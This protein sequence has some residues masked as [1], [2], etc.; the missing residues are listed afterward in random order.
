[1]R[2]A[3]SSSCRA[4]PQCYS[5]AHPPPSAVCPHAAHQPR[6]PERS[7]RI[8]GP[9]LL[10]T[11]VR[12]AFHDCASAT[13]DGCIDTADALN[14]PGLGEMQQ[15]LQPLCAN[16]SLATADCWAAAASIALEEASYNGADLARVPLF[17]GRADTATCTG[18]TQRNPEALFP[19]ASA[20]AALEPHTH[21]SSSTTACTPSFWRSTRLFLHLRHRR[22]HDPDWRALF[23][24]T[25]IASCPV[26]P[27]HSSPPDCRAFLRRI[28]DR[29][30][31]WKVGMYGTCWFSAPHVTCTD[32][33]CSF[34]RQRGGPAEVCTGGSLS[35]ALW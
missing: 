23:A 2:A 27:K 14:N 17:F 20:G 13:C 30:R 25:Q 33:Q 7:L 16:H 31:I 10:R 34:N 8:A 18:F 26:A 21:R 24:P 19:A 9:P 6:S 22:C 4:P 29:Y 15:A 1:M 28:A 12:L 3:Q 32:S 11:L 5:H 35:A